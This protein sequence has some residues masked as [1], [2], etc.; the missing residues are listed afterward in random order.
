MPQSQINWRQI[1][2]LTLG[3]AVA[4]FNKRINKIQNE[5]NKLYLP[6]ELNYKDVKENITTRSELR[7]ILNS[8]RRFSKEGAEDIYT[9]KSGIKLTKW[10][11]NELN[12]QSRI[13]TRRLNKE[14]SS[15]NEIG[16]TGF[17]RVQMGSIREKE[18]KRQLENLKSLE[19][20]TG[21]EFQRL[22]NRIHNIGTSDYE[23][24]KAI[25]YRENYLET[26][27]KYS[28]F[29]NYENLMSKLNSIKNPISFFEFVSQN[30][31]AG[32][33]TYQSDQAYSQ[34]EFNRFLESLGIELTNDDYSINDIFI[35]EDREQRNVLHYSLLVNGIA[36]AHSDSLSVIRNQALNY[37]GR[38]TYIIIDN[39]TNSII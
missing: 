11:Y 30:E 13:A 21:Y 38:G 28:H 24:K 34:M 4:N 27:R 1:D 10:E 8:L 15:L 23:M 26:M 5:E 17:S 33:L 2:Y 39:F 18:I 16:E 29:D 14:L 32:D 22:R 37:K 9:M 19:E 7:R 12:L 31:I 20:K 3:R 6:N 35:N 36:I 25:V